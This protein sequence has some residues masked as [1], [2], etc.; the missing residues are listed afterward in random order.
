MILRSI[1]FASSKSAPAASFRLIKIT[2]NFP[3]YLLHNSFSFEISSPS[4]SALKRLNESRLIYIVKPHCT[5]FLKVFNT[6]WKNHFTRHIILLPEH[7]LLNSINQD[8]FSPVLPQA[9]SDYF[10]FLQCLD[11]LLCISQ[12]GQYFLIVLAECRCRAVNP[13]HHIH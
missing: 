4:K 2:G 12:P 1:P 10:F 5:H 11:L 9:F 13:R 7:D 3:I 6:N 8:R